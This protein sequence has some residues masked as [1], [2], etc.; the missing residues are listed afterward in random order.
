MKV[1]RTLA[2]ILWKLHTRLGRLAE[3]ARRRYLQEPAPREPRAPRVPQTATPQQRETVANAL[4][5]SFCGDLILLRDMVEN[6][7]RRDGGYDFSPMFQYVAPYWKEA[8][9]AV[10]VFEGPMAGEAAGYSDSC[11]GDGIP[12]HLNFPDEFAHALKAAGIGLVSTAHNHVLDKGAQAIPRTLQVLEE[13]GLGHFGSHRSAEESLRVK[14]VCLG[15]VKIAFLGF[16]YG[17]NYYTDDY[18]FSPEHRHETH[19]LVRLPNPRLEECKAAVAAAF[20]RAR[21]LNPDLIV[22]M[23]H[24]GRE[25]TH[26]PNDTQLFWVDFMIEQ[27][28]DIIM[29]DHAHCVQPVEWRKRGKDDVLVSYCPGNLLSSAT[30][31]DG[32]ASMLVEAY[33]DPHTRRPVAAGIVPL[34]A[35][36]R[37]YAGGHAGFR[38]LPI[39]DAL[40]NP[41]LGSR[42]S[43]RDEL[44]IREAHHVIT[45]SALGVDL[46]SHR[47][48]RRYF[49]FPGCG[50]RSNPAPA[51]PPEDLPADSPLVQAM[52]SAGRALFI[53]GNV[54]SGAAVGGYGW[55]EPLAAAFPQLRAERFIPAHGTAF[56][57][58]AQAH[59]IAAAQA[60]LFVLAL[61]MQDICSHAPDTCAMTAQAY[62]QSI[63][64]VTSCIAARHPQARIILIAP[65]PTHP[66]DPACPLGPEEKQALH[67]DFCAALQDFADAAALQLL[68]PGPA[69]ERERAAGFWG[70]CMLNQTLPNAQAGVPLYARA[71]ARACSASQQRHI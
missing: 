5:L 21:A 66:Q 47:L 57:A 25:F 37:A 32:D 62:V 69:I 53:G 29:A 41:E 9:L 8:D 17:C 7:R 34:F 43:R 28:A 50:Y 40:T 16:T 15:S 65:W 59:E 10:G 33:I 31:R 20:A 60:E 13:A 23:P 6:A 1:K 56:C 2:R 44:R 27:G 12:L 35:H 22:A 55:F 68:N 67:R 26:Q 4:C 3:K 45:S 14:T 70:C 51:L 38:A 39:Y 64:T 42:L 48:E 36:S 63:R 30:G 19:R 54:T 49:T 18:F 52:Q 11:L 61:G 71:A 58:A 24:M 46:Q